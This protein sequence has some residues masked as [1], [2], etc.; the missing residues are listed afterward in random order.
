MYKIYFYKAPEQN[1]LTR[2]AIA[3]NICNTK[4]SIML[5]TEELN[6]LFPWLIV[7]PFNYFAKKKGHPSLL[8]Y[9][10][11][12]KLMDRFNSEHEMV[13]CIHIISFLLVL[14]LVMQEN[15]KLLYTV[16][17]CWVGFDCQVLELFQ[18]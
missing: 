10:L 18:D 7:Y 8:F 17:N 16:V 4:G 5:T 2:K 12:Y 6:P 13:V 11:A 9:A 15:R 3:V 14:L 1:K